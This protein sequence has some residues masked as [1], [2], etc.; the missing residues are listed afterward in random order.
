MMASAPRHEVFDRGFELGAG[1]RPEDPLGEL[2]VER[3]V[4]V[5]LVFAFGDQDVQGVAVAEAL[6]EVAA[7]H[8]VAAAEQADGLEAAPEHL[9]R[10]WIDDVEKGQVD[11]PPARLSR[12]SLAT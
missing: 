8:R 5:L 6:D 11:A 7:G 4:D 12:A 10:G 2:V 9:A 1:F 3:V